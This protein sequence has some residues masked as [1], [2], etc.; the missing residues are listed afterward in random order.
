MKMVQLTS[1]SAIFLIL[2]LTA[3]LSA[4]SK[5]GRYADGTPYRIDADGS[6]IVDQLAE[7][8]LEKQN[9]HF[10]IQALEKD[11]EEKENALENRRSS[12]PEPRLY[13]AEEDRKRTEELAHLKQELKTAESKRLNLQNKL[14]EFEKGKESEEVLIANTRKK[15]QEIEVLKK[16]L[17]SYREELEKNKEVIKGHEKQSR[18]LG[19][20]LE[21][22]GQE[23]METK[24]SVKSEQQRILE[25][26]QKAMYALQKKLER[27]KFENELLSEKVKDQRNPRAESLEVYNADLSPRARYDFAPSVRSVRPNVE[28]KPKLDQGMM[29]QAQ[30]YIA[31]IEGGMALRDRLFSEYNKKPGR[32]VSFKPRDLKATSG[33]S[34]AS[35]RARVHRVTTQG[36]L[37]RAMGGLRSVLSLVRDDI[38]LVQRLNK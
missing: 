31:E 38:A 9:A 27:A 21:K 30:R 24:E 32:V 6:E 25:E 3:P 13:V 37:T 7:L 15:E 4:E 35:L 5:V 16:Q 36:E 2:A 23:L 1:S 28:P 11:L 10:R 12:Q 33:E 22:T 34:F 19:A 18:V 14:T 17:S 8:E 26:Q 20:E 29:A